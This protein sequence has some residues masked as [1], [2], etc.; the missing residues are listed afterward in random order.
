MKWWIPYLQDFEARMP[1]EMQR[2]LN[3][4][5]TRGPDSD[6]DD[7]V[8][9]KFIEKSIALFNDNHIYERAPNG[10]F[11]VNGEESKPHPLFD[12]FIA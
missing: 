6:S 9:D 11:C 7:D 5:I 4:V 12:S 1:K 3:P 8:L 2:D 10:M